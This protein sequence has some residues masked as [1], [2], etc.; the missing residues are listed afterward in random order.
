MTM[1]LLKVYS[2]GTSRCTGRMYENISKQELIELTPRARAHFRLGT[3]A[4]K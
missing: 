2:I 4:L 3:E 1:A